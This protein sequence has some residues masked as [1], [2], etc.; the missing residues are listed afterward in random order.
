[1]IAAPVGAKYRAMN[2]MAPPAEITSRTYSGRILDA[3][4]VPV[5][6]CIGF[7]AF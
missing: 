3:P 5:P 2:C 4:S 6:I 1:M 7:E